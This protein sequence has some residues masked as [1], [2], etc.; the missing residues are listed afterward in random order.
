MQRTEHLWTTLGAVAAAFALLFATP[1]ADAAS[2]FATGGPASAPAAPELPGTAADMTQPPDRAVNRQTATVP[3]WNSGFEFDGSGWGSTMVGTDPAAGS[4]TTTVPVVIVPLRMVFDGDGTV[5]EDAGAVDDVVASPLFQP[6]PFPTGTTQYGDAFR[7]ADFWDEVS[8]EAPGYHTLLGDP[9]VAPTQTLHVPGAK[10]VTAFNAAANRTFGYVESD[11]FSRQLK[12]LI[13]SLHIDPGALVIVLSYNTAVSQ[14]D[15][16][17]CL[18]PPGCAVALG[19]HGA[20]VNGNSVPASQPAQSLNT[21]VYAAYEDFGD[22]VPPAFNEHFDALSHELLEWMD[23]PIAT[24]RQADDAFGLHA[25]G[26]FVPG[27]TP[28]SEPPAGC[29]YNDEVA[30]PVQTVASVGVPDRGRIDL[31]ADAVFQSWFAH[32]SP[33]TSFGG[34]YDLIGVLPS[35]S[36]GC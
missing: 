8:A 20:Q 7:R 6:T 29:R 30:D 18:V 14:G 9:T 16:S 13:A 10:G 24:G 28:V 35:F 21:F 26:S 11:W 36:P 15:P 32:R 12:S 23:D 19:Y 1:T 3:L 17:S 5:L 2:P 4:A 31:L 33:S 22:E 25:F 27:W 34:R